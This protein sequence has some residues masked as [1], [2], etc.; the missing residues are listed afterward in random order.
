MKPI[1]RIM[2]MLAI[3]AGMG[4]SSCSEQEDVPALS[5]AQIILDEPEVRLGRTGRYYEVEVQAPAACTVQSTA[6]WLTLTSDTLPSD[7]V[8]EFYVT[9]NDDDYGRSAEIRVNSAGQ[10]DLSAS[11]SVY[12]CGWLDSDDNALAGG[13]LTQD[14]R[15]GWGY[16]ILQEFMSENSLT[17]P[18]LD[19][20]K[21]LGFEMET[22]GKLIQEDNRSYEKIE[23]YSGYS[24]DELSQTF[25]E[26]QEKEKSNLFGTKKTVSR[27][28]KT[29]DYSTVEERCYGYSRLSKVVASRYLD[30]AGLL[31]LVSEGKDIYSEVFG[32]MRQKVIENPTVENVDRMLK[33]FG[34]HL[35][36]S[37]DVGGMIEYMVDFQKKEV[38]DVQTYT[39]MRA[40]YVYGQASASS[41]TNRIEASI[42]TDCQASRSFTIRAGDNECVERIKSAIEDFSN[43]SQIDQQMLA[44]WMN[45]L[46]GDYRNDKDLRRRLTIVGCTTLPIWMFF[47]ADLAP[48]IRDRVE[49]MASQSNYDYAAGMQQGNN[50]KISL[51]DAMLRFGEGNDAPL[52]KVVYHGKVPVAE[53]C[54]E[55]VPDIRADRRVTVMYP[56]VKGSPNLNRGIFL[57]DGD[58]NPPAY[59]AFE[60]G[61]AYVNPIEGQTSHDQL[62]TLYY[63]NG[64]LYLNDMGK[65]VAYDG[66]TVEDAYCVLVDNVTD[67]LPFVKIG[68]G[69][70]LRANLKHSIYLGIP[71]DPDYEYSNVIVNEMF[72]GDRYYTNTFGVIDPTYLSMNGSFIGEG[73]WYLPQTE[74]V[75]SLL[76]FLYKNPKALF[77]GQPSGFGAQFDGFYGV[78]DIM[79]QDHY[80]GAFGFHYVDEYC[81]IACKDDAQTGTALV[82]TPDYML[83]TTTLKAANDNFYP[84]RLFR[85]SEFAYQEK[86]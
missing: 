38:T 15:V 84:V 45:S 33:D 14:F 3:M 79:N 10:P 5:D 24:L 8:L 76:N 51:T 56:L 64:N 25:T 69:Y 50:C 16:N 68:S 12:Q 59:V 63:V 48:M 61:M 47:P 81:I 19:Y 70:W 74:D 21:L 32:R 40:K 1:F 27:F 42:S 31:Y 35:V 55:Y 4:F 78:Y 23:V 37:A 49:E 73:K 60:G 2:S 41:E 53:I 80:L 28:V 57:G 44:D 9:A 86:E 6:E 39:E 71:E 82:L 43:E 29:N 34:T 18:I 62:R 11:L 20:N 54:N 22:G 52:V 85:S 72:E 67:R 30:E 46:E 66:V 65:G 75:T 58:G 36:L 13:E 77:A 17:A 7:G 83:R 26:V